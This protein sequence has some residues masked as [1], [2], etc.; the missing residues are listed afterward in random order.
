VTVQ[1]HEGEG[2]TFTLYVPRGNG[3]PRPVSESVKEAG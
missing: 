3:T 2:S 1:S